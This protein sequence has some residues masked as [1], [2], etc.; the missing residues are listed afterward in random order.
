MAKRKQ[1]PLRVD[2]AL[3]EAVERWAADDLRSVN[4]QVEF[5]L[6]RALKDAGRLKK[7]DDGEAPSDD[8]GDA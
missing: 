6:R 8:G 3:W 5:I 4:A 7:P 1:Y 2:P